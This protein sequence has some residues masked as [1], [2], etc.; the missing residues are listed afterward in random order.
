MRSSQP[1]PVWYGRLKRFPDFAAT[2]WA[3]FV[4]NDQYLNILLSVSMGSVA[5]EALYLDDTTDKCEIVDLARSDGQIRVFDTLKPDQVTII[6]CQAG[7]LTPTLRTLSAIGFLDNV[8]R[9]RLKIT[10]LHVLGSTHAS[11]EEIKTVS[12]LVDGA[13]HVLVKNH[14]NEGSY[15]GLSDEL[16]AAANG[17]V[18][19]IQ[20]LDELVAD[21]V[22][23]AGVLFDAFAKNDVNSRVMRGYVNSWLDKVFAEYDSIRLS[24]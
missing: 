21:H 6:D 4:G 12:G 16:R 23:R 3:E 15:L 5:Y 10:V 7:S 24:D 9:G 13:K 11:L 19:N 20:K 1:L 8:K 22:D 2:P 18:I 14:I 17:G